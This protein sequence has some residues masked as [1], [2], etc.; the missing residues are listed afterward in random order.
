[1]NPNSNCK[2]G[3]KH[4]LSERIADLKFIKTNSTKLTKFWKNMKINWI[5]NIKNPFEKFEIN[6]AGF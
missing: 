2:V 4:K 5:M 6:E 1:M 3:I